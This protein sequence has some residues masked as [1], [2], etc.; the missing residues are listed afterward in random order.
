MDHNDQEKLSSLAA[1]RKDVFDGGSP[2][3]ASDDFF[4]II[5]ENDEDFVAVLDLEGRRIYNNPSYARIFGDA[6]SIKGLDSFSEIHPDDQRRVKT[7]FRDTVQSGTSHRLNFR[8]VLADGSIRHM[9]SCGTL[10]RNSQGHALRV[11]VV[12]RDITERL[13]KE[14][15]ILNLAFYDS[16]TQLPNRHLLSDRLDQAMSISKRSGRYG[17]LMFID[18][19]NFK[20][21]NDKH[22]HI[23]GD[24]LLPEVGRR[25][26]TCLREMDTVA[27][28][29]G[30]EFVLVLSE[31]STD[32]AKSIE[33]SRIVAEKISSI[34]SEPYVLKLQQNGSLEKT[35]EFHCTASIGVVLFINHEASKEDILKRADVTMYQAKVVGR[36][37]IRFYDLD[38]E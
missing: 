28:Y 9:E 5:V 2:A 14:Q 33:Q 22:G 21:L 7:A 29:G 4:R 27:R 11:V 1:Y 32:K 30:D 6:E 34:L 13:L 19:D 26:T 3:H 17:A 10:V 31:L 35:I 8:F 38:S 37:C 23:A 25:I 24:L 16:L 12:S 36:N 20:Q 15:E 18:L